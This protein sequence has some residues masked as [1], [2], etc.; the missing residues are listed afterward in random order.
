MTP[1]KYAVAHWCGR[2]S[3]LKSA[4]VN[5]VAMYFVLVLGFVGL[6]RWI[7]IYAGMAV[8][9]LWSIWA[10][11]GI[12]RCGLRNALNPAN[13]TVSRIGGAVAIVGV[14][15]VVFFTVKDLVHLGI[16]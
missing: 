3:L 6:S 4:L 8:F 14:L 11:V 5:G 1:S 10:A 13:G 7:N 2:L 16:L 15:C 9:L 12:F